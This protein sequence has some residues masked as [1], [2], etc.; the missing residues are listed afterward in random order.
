MLYAPASNSKLRSIFTSLIEFLAEKRFRVKHGMTFFAGMT[1]QGC[2]CD[3][4]TPKLGVS[5]MA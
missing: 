1:A 4:E 2:G 5:T 3:V